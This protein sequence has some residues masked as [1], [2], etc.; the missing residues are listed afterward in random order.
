MGWKASVIIV[1]KP[2]QIGDEQLL[3]EL[4]FDRLVKIKDELFEAVI[5]PANHRVYIG[6][7]KDNLLI[8]APDIPMQIIESDETEAEKVLVKLFPDSEICSIVLHSTVNLWGYA[9]IKSGDRIRVMAGSAEDGTF[10]DS[11]EPLEEEKKILSKSV[12][13]EAGQRTYVFEEI[14]NEVM[15][16]DQVGENFV[17]AICSRYFGEELDYADTL[18]FETALRGYSY[19]EVVQV[20]KPILKG[21]A[22]WKFW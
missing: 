12:V 9:I 17:F 13:D 11:G 8:C 21:K 5:N 22:W 3:K 1:H 7:Y 14:D 19:G 18:L 4:R 16:E 20:S 2:M 6:N 15:T 10:I